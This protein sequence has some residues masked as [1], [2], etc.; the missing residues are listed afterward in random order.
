MRIKNSKNKIIL[1]PIIL[2]ILSSCV[3]QK[4]LIYL[5]NKE[6]ATKNEFLNERSEDYKVQPGD[7]LYIKITSINEETS[8]LFNT[9][10]SR[11][12]Q[13]LNNDVSVYLNS[14]TVAEDGSIDFPLTGKINV[15]NQTIEEVKNSI[16]TVLEEY[17][18]E[19]LIIVKLINFNITLLGEIER[20]G[21]YKVYQDKINLFEAIAMAGDLGDFA[22]RAKVK[23]IR[24][25]KTGTEIHQLDLTNQKILE[26][27]Y[28]YLMPNDVIYVEPL[29]GKQFTFA[30]FPYTVVFSA[31]STLILM[32]NYIK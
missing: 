25:T 5:Q 3:P 17:L 16:Y 22:N 7:N 32:L 30:N 9:S 19:T 1:F 18:K 2:I 4:K 24:Q 8:M 10:T 27:D 12:S 6:L 20:P 14:Y 11:Y 21:Q 13:N 23:L 31:I 28:Y 29:K 15:Q 26:S